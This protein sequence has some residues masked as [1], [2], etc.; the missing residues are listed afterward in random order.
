MF[1]F[2]VATKEA[3]THSSR[4]TRPTGQSSVT[5]NCSHRKTASL[6]VASFTAGVRMI[7]NF[8]FVR[9]WMQGKSSDGIF[10]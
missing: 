8:I 1:L 9:T 3:L 4:E 10:L 5:L 7:Q 6:I 2:F